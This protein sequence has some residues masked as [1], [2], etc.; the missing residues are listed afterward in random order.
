MICTTA[1]ACHACGWIP[2]EPIL[3][4]MARM[5]AL[6]FVAL[7]A[8][9]CGGRSKLLAHAGDS[10]VAIIPPGPDASRD[11]LADLSPPDAGP[12]F[13]DVSPNDTRTP[14]PDGPPILPDVV[15]TPDL[16][17]IPPPGPDSG[18]EV[19]ATYIAGVPS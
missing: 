12:V 10:A 7:T 9:G 17:V 16:V 4:P 14:Q 15:R 3:A 6:A 18:M 2:L 11:A 8:V 19:P 5:K 1:Q 13:P